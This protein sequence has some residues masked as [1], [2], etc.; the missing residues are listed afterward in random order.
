SGNCHARRTGG[1]TPRRTEPGVGRADASPDLPCLHT[2]GTHRT[3]GTGP[4]PRPLASG[5]SAVSG[6][7]AG[8]DDLE[9]PAAGPHVLPHPVPAIPTTRRS[10]RTARGAPGAARRTGRRTT[11]TGSRG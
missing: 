10:R 8:G 4:G 2:G 9:R 5:R 7:P 3:T 11:R 1:P 6:F